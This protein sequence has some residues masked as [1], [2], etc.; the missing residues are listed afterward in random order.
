MIL[1]FL[2]VHL[3]AV[4]EAVYEGEHRDADEEIKNHDYEAEIAL[5]DDL[6]SVWVVDVIDLAAGEGQ[7]FR[8]D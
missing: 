5:A 6:S 3:L 1:E 7:E 8:L 4:G 2:D